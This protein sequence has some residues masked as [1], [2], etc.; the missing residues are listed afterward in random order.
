[1]AQLAEA[2]MS[3]ANYKEHCAACHGEDRW[4]ASARR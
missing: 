3:P 4:A 2:A 1:M